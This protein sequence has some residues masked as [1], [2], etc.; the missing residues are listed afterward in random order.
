MISSKL[1]SQNWY[2][3]FEHFDW[4]IAKLV[5]ILANQNAQISE[6]SFYEVNLEIILPL[7]YLPR[8]R[9]YVLCPLRLLFFANE[10]NTSYRKNFHRDKRSN[11]EDWFFFVLA[12]PFSVSLKHCAHDLTLRTIRAL[13][14]KKVGGRN[15]TF[16]VLKSS[17]NLR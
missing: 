7:I 8:L 14:E 5:F 10:C 2:P 4:L 6:I 15:L 1:I 11:E 13:E 16:I 17:R 12:W 3:K 9:T